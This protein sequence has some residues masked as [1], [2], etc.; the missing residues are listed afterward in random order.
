MPASPVSA[1]GLYYYVEVP[2]AGEARGSGLEVCPVLRHSGEWTAA[3]PDRTFMRVNTRRKSAATAEPGEN[4]GYVPFGDI[5]AGEEERLIQGAQDFQDRMASSVRDVDGTGLGLDDAGLLHGGEALGAA[6]ATDHGGSAAGGSSQPYIAPGFQEAIRRRQF[7][8][9]GRFRR[10]IAAAKQKAVE[11]TCSTGVFWFT[12]TKVYT[13][14][15][16]QKEVQGVLL[17]PWGV[18]D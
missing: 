4:V 3:K 13:Y 12:C 10:G 7:R 6:V 1:W 16:E 8:Y 15:K 5:E 14:M 2:P 17:K 9:R 11:A 18:R